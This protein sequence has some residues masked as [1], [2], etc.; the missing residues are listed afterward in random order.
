MNQNTVGSQATL[1]S[2][3]K[4]NLSLTN[5]KHKDWTTATKPGTLPRSETRMRVAIVRIEF[6]TKKQDKIAKDQQCTTFNF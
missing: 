5:R 1:T 6:I 2:A 4:T 3:P